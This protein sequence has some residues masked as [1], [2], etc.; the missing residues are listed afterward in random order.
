MP[1]LLPSTITKDNI[2]NN[3]V[4]LSE[5][6]ATF[7]MEVVCTFIF[8]LYIL[9]VTGERTKT[10]NMGL[11]IPASICL[12]LWALCKVDAFTGAS[13]NPALAVGSTFFQAWAYSVNP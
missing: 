6:F 2:N 11:W 8:V 4:E 9:H 5:G 13:F 7:Y 12:V 1:L 3:T 10:A